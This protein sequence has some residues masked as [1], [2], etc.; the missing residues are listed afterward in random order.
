MNEAEFIII[1]LLILIIGMILYGAYYVVNTDIFKM[2]MYIQ[3]NYKVKNLEDF[4]HSS[5]SLMK[6]YSFDDVDKFI[7][8]ATTL[9]NNINSDYSNIKNVINN[10]IPYFKKTTENICQKGLTIDMGGHKK[11]KAKTEDN[12]GGGILGGILDSVSNTVTNVI[13]DTTPSMKFPIKIDC[14][15]SS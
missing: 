12:F 6:K 14:N 9:I 15:N 8:S 5:S 11:E 1:F 13:K 4:L 7:K 3:K 10:D 2:L